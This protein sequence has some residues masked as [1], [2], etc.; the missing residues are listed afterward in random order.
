MKEEGEGFYEWNLFVVPRAIRLS[1][2]LF[3]R[4][5]LHMGQDCETGHLEVGQH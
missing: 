4:H 3:Y 2:F 5:D 1:L